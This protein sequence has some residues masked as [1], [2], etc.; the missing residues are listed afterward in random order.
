M[1]ETH[2]DKEIRKKKKKRTA[3]AVY[4]AWFGEL[5]RGIYTQATPKFKKSSKILPRINFD[6]IFLP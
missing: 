3:L 6:H 2:C 1:R 5:S 4:K